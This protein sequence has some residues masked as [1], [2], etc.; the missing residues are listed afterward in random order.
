MTYLNDIGKGR[1]LLKIAYL[2]QHH[3]ARS[4]QWHEHSEVLGKPDPKSTRHDLLDLDL[5]HF[6]FCIYFAQSRSSGTTMFTTIWGEKKTV[7][8]FIWRVRLCRYPKGT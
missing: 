2:D 1:A 6:T 7:G 4:R 5:N 8:L 3:I